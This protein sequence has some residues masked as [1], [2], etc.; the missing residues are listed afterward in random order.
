[1]IDQVEAIKFVREFS[2]GRT[3]YRVAKILGVSWGS[4]N[5]WLSNNPKKISFNGLE[6]IEKIK[7]EKTAK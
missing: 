5:N 7:K 2:K 1:M 6:S 3:R 4:V